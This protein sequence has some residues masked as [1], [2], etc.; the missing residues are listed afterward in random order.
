MIPKQKIKN[1]DLILSCE[2]TRNELSNFIND[3]N[4][5]TNIDS[6]KKRAVLQGKTK[7]FLLNIKNFL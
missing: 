7:K 3:E 6:A 1:S 2:N 5:R 4:I